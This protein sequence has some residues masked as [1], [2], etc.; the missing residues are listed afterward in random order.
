[1]DKNKFNYNEKYESEFMSRLHNKLISPNKI[2]SFFRLIFNTYCSHYFK[3]SKKHSKLQ[4]V[5]ID[6]NKI[7]LL[8]G[9]PVNNS[10]IDGKICTL[11][12]TY[13]ETGTISKKV[14]YSLKKYAEVSD[15]I[16]VIGDYELS[17]S[18]EYEKICN[19]VNCA[20]FERHKQYDVGSWSKALK[21]L[22]DT[23]RLQD[24]DYLVLVNDSVYGPLYSLDK[25]YLEME[26]KGCDFWGITDNFEPV[27]HIQSYFTIYKKNVFMSKLF[28]DFFSR[29]P[30][31]ISFETAVQ[32][33]EL[34]ITNALS[35]KFIHSAL[36]SDFCKNIRASIS[37]NG[38]P[39]TWPVDLLNAGSPFIKCK[40]LNR[41]Y[42]GD[43]HQSEVDVVDSVSK[44]DSS[45]TD[46]I[47][48]D[49]FWLKEKSYDSTKVLS[50]PVCIDK[51]LKDIEIV[52]FDIFDTLL[53][54]PFVEPSDLFDYIGSKY[55]IHEFSEKRRLA[56]Q[57]ARMKKSSQEV[58]IN[59][60]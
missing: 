40:A 38:N 44:I 59:D 53:I 18:K 49:N 29:M 60:I 57:N 48:N 20:Y 13:S 14:Q 58:T 5:K 22:Q 23:G 3:Q 4:S 43:L 1:M 39:T 32:N 52:S 54:R 26:S 55:G 8:N 16:F 45:L 24:Y 27:H 51:Y 41:T 34:K 11:F 28:L 42:G 15:Y 37:G 35:S 33:Y 17:N 6:K 9:M 36:I 50:N 12:A 7:K 10:G 47:L 30:E 56:E 19:F 31:E 21:Y 2:N 25:I 46:I